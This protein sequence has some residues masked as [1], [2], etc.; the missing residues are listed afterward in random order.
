VTAFLILSG[1]FCLGYWLSYSLRFTFSSSILV[2]WLLLG[3][4]LIGASLAGRWRLWLLMP[5]ALFFLCFFLFLLFAA[6][7]KKERE[8]SPGVIL[9]LG[10]RRDGTLPEAL[11]SGRVQ[12][13]RAYLEKYPDAVAILSGGT[14][15]G[16]K[17]SEAE[18]L[19]EALVSCGVSPE[20]LIREEKSKSTRENFLFSQPL[21]PSGTPVLAVT[22][23]YHAFR[24]A[25][26]AKRIFPHGTLRVAGAPF[27]SPFL[28]HLY[29]REFFTFLV[30]L[31]RGN[32][33]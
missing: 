4:Y 16:E 10:V 24:A 33:V 23:R 1:L 32:I 29:L 17:T 2:F 3:L 14:V 19:F 22:S 8:F 9:V 11:F 7:R 27:F 31:F 21:L 6:H 25:C 26:L 30:D 28:L 18:A 20:R 5:V 13:A 15:F 12:L